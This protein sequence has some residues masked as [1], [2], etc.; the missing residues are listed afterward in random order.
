MQIHRNRLILMHDVAPRGSPE[1]IDPKLRKVAYLFRMHCCMRAEADA[2]IATPELST[3][4]D[5]ILAAG[6]Q[7]ALATT[8]NITV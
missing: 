6:L 8:E 7:D 5:A 1:K 3:L 2:S 4:V